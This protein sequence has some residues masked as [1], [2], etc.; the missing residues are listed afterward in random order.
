MLGDVQITI[1][2]NFD[3]CEP[4]GR[5]GQEQNGSAKRKTDSGSSTATAIGYQGTTPGVRVGEE[6]RGAAARSIGRATVV[7]EGS[8]SG[9][10]KTI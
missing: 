6:R 1:A 2:K 7:D 9:A 4:A 3:L 5:I 8:G 10:R